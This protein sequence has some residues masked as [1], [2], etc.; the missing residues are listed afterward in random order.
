MLSF[1]E[2]QILNKTCAKMYEW[3]CTMQ[4]RQ[5]QVDLRCCMQNDIKADPHDS[6]HATH[7][8]TIMTFECE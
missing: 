5:A 7:E 8:S 1:D 2:H 4:I 6:C 3:P